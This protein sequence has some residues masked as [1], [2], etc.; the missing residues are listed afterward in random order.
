MSLLYCTCAP[1]LKVHAVSSGSAS[2]HTKAVKLTPT[3]RFLLFPS[4]L[5]LKEKLDDMTQLKVKGLVLGPFH[6]VQKD[7]PATLNLELIDPSFGSLD[8]LKEVLE[9][10]HKKGRSSKLSPQFHCS[11][12]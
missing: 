8:K 12:Q 7:K 10:A 2:V 11:Y 4:L 1:T 3:Q 9:R 6:R 5:G